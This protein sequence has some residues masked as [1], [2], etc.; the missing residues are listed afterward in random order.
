MKHVRIVQLLLHAG[1]NPLVV[2]RHGGDSPLHVVGDCATTVQ[3]LLD[4]GAQR[5]LRNFRGETP[6]DVAR[7]A[8]HSAALQV[9]ESAALVPEL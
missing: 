4:G 7:A 9:L 6:I 2:T 3:A 1:A 5:G 8:G